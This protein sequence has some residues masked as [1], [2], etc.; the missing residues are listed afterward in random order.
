MVSAFRARESPRTAQCLIKGFLQA[1]EIEAVGVLEL[2][3]WDLKRRKTPLSFCNNAVR[4][5]SLGVYCGP[6][7][8]AR[9]AAA[10]LESHVPKARALGQ[11]DGGA[12]LF[13]DLD[14]EAI[15]DVN[16]ARAEGQKWPDKSMQKAAGIAPADARTVVRNL[17]TA[18]HDDPIPTG[19]DNGRPRQP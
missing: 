19:L 13:I 4:F 10:E 5:F 14:Y 1:R 11:F 8:T 2:T 15:L 12:L 3:G 7:P 9:T 16:D 6:A 17:R 18:G